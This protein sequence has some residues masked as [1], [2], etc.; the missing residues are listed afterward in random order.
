MCSTGCTQNNPCNKCQP[1]TEVQ[2][3]CDC[4]ITD[5]KSDCILFTEDLECSEIEAG[6]TLTET[7]VQLDTAICDKISQL[8]DSINI[9]STGAGQVIYNGVD[10]LGRRKIKSITK[11]GNLITLTSNTDDLAFSIDEN[12]LNTFVENS[13]KTYSVSNLGDAG[14]GVLR[15]VQQNTNDITIRSKK[16]SSSTLTVTS[17]EEQVFIDTPISTSNLSFY[18]DV[19]STSDLETGSLSSPFKT[20]N[21]ALDAFIGTGTW[22]NPEFK[23]YKITLLSACSLIEVAGVGYNG[24]VNLD[25]NNLNIEGNGFYLGLYAN[26]SVDYYPISTRR[27]V[28]NIPK[29]ANILDYSID[30]DFNN[31]T[32]QR[33]GTNAIVDHLNYSFPAATLAGSFPPQQNGSRIWFINCTLTNDTDLSV[34]ANFNTVSNPSDSGNPLLLFGRPVYASS[35]EPIGVPMVKTEGRN[36]NKEGSLRLG[37]SRL[38]NSL[39]TAIRAINTTYN[40]NY[41]TCEI[42]M[43]NYYRLFETLVDNYYSPRLGFAMI[44]LEDVNYFSINNIRL[45][46][47]MPRMDT[48]ELI[49]RSRIIGGVESIFKLKNS[50]IIIYGESSE[51]DQVE[52]LI[53]LDGTSNIILDG[54]ENNGQV[55]DNIHGLIKVITPL[56]V[57][58]LVLGFNRSILY[59]VKVDETEVDKSFIRQINGVLNTIN[60][61]PHNTYLQYTNDTVAKSAGLIKGNVYFN[62]TVGALKN[63]V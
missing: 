27:M 28:A 36:W 31:I 41:D 55:S 9:I 11:T 10:N 26:P 29:T 43:P 57:N 38:F 50:F 49:P 20:L 30:L 63:I 45:N 2:Q 13:Q 60:Y 7:I 61:A 51:Q 48:T 17:D 56:P 37:N 8:E 39:G 33:I 35:S 44:D 15:D 24:Y 21:K 25:I 59:N 12:A 46:W 5:L 22:Y 14:E 54:Y 62:T 3:N 23:G 40:D 47:T 19:N 32:F 52:N 18:V 42:S 4:P 53:Q 58:S 6:Q 34:S 1:C 16:I